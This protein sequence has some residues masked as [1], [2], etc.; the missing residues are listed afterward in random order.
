MH[1]VEVFDALSTSEGYLRKHFSYNGV[2][3]YNSVPVQCTSSSKCG[4]FTL[5]FL[6]NRLYNLDLEL[7]DL[8]NDIFVIDCEQN[9]EI[10]M[11]FFQQL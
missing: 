8:I 3:Q 5:Y 9:E 4:Q 11:Q 7:V 2:Y 1:T 10:V 6:I